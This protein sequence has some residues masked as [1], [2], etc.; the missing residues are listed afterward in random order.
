MP[1]TTNPE[2]DLLAVEML[3]EVFSHGGCVV[4]VAL[5]SPQAAERIE[6]H[7]SDPAMNIRLMKGKALYKDTRPVNERGLVNIPFVGDV[8]TT[9]QYGPDLAK[10]LIQQICGTA[11]VRPDHGTEHL[12][13]RSTNAR[14]APSRNGRVAMVDRVP[15]ARLT[16]H[17]RH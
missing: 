6:P 11:T 7:K 1:E 17:K 10:R 15:V 8:D 14:V 9:K 13:E 12:S 4:Y 5:P 3:D 2:Y 16:A